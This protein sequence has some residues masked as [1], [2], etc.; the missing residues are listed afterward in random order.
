MTTRIRPAT[1]ADADAIA[2]LHFTAW[3]VGYRGILPDEL[4]D[5]LELG[6]WTDR[7]RGHLKHPAKG[8]FNFVGLLEDDIAGWSTVGPSRDK[9]DDP[10]EVGELYG[11]YVDPAQWR[12]GVGRSMLAAA[13]DEL[14]RAGYEQVTL[15]VLKA[16]D[17]ARAL[18]E[19]GGLVVDGAEKPC[20]VR[21]IQEPS[22]RYRLRF[23]G[24][25][26]VEVPEDPEA[27]W[28]QVALV[29]DVAEG[30]QGVRADGLRLL[31]GR[32]DGGAWFAVDNTCPHEGY[33]LQ[34]GF[35]KDCVVTCAWHNW[36]FDVR[37]GSNVLGG[38][39]IR[40]WPT[41]IVGDAL[42]VDV[43]RPPLAVQIP[44]RLDSL[45]AGLVDGSVDR[46]L[47]DCVRLLQAGLSPADLLVE[48]ARDD[49][50]RAEYGTTHVLPICGDV[51][52]LDLP[53]GLD[54]VEFLVPAIAMACERN[55]RLPLRSRSEPVPRGDRAAI[56]RIVEQENVDLAEAVVRG[57]ARAEQPELDHWLLAATS[58]HFTDFGHSLIFLARLRPLLPAMDVEARAD[59]LGGFAFGL[60][61]A[62]REDTLPYLRRYVRTLEEREDELPRLFAAASPDAPF[63]EAQFR[64]SVL[65]GTATEACDVL[66]S[67]LEAGVSASRIAR[68]LV[69]ASASRLLRFDLEVEFDG[70]VAEGWLWAT[71]RFTFASAVRETVE[72][73]QDPD[74]LRFLLQAVAFIHSGK[75]M[76]APSERRVNVGSRIGSAEDLR[77][78]L[79]GRRA[80][81][82][83]AFANTAA[84]S[85]DERRV[86]LD[87]G[88][89]DRFVRPIFS[90][91]ALKSAAAALR[92]YDALGDHPDRSL[93]AVAVARF[94]ASPVIED[95]R[96]DQ[97]R[98]AVRFVVDGKP[99]KKLTQ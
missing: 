88:L 40:T 16:N 93:P 86:L 57:L 44:K 17:G 19:A 94:L 20:G 46:C 84:W 22:V 65:D 81:D 62:T 92:E 34:Q 53:D 23:D 85:A 1:V 89:G 87:P 27:R 77:A 70:E 2:R 73:W 5:G 29:A 58:R 71:H 67:A 99:P 12:N 76:D 83:I 31:V 6:P 15:W 78:A 52:E 55:R 90:A 28:V 24:A 32:T 3:Q 51:A 11:L 98:G 69:L 45:R 42:E 80:E 35:Q 10:I 96:R 25:E 39:G 75:G 33:P 14:Q 8:I 49:A 47:R 66:W 26:D 91:H 37:D 82:A 18:Y 9:D 54:A 50:K 63:D 38:E 74:V 36:K 7:R 68:A 21:D 61:Q 64:R 97:A 60:P 79:S 30:M 72:R 13:L 95:R 59:I 48:I 43:Q 41:R 56:I 4:L